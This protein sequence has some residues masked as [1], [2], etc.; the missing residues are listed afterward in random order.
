[1]P[2]ASR[3]SGL[4][5]LVAMLILAIAGALIY[6]YRHVAPRYVPRPGQAE[7]GAADYFSPADNLERLD[8]EQLQRAGRTIDIAMYAFT[9]QYLAQQLAEIARRGVVIRIYRDR[10]QYEQEQRRAGQRD[11]ESA[12]ELLRGISNIHVRVKRSRELMHLKA[13]LVDAALLRDGSANWSPSGLKRQ[14][15]NAH[16]STD[17]AVIRRFQQVFE[18]MWSRSDNEEIQ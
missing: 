1:L 3:I 5:K 18:E 2:G 17:P 12:M 13:Y 10:E 16:F 11:R 6:Q 7:A 8:L 14:D 15:N 9:D 4:A